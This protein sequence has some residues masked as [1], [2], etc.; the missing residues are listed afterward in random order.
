MHCENL[1]YIASNG[2]FFQR[3]ARYADDT[4]RIEGDQRHRLSGSVQGESRININEFLR[5]ASFL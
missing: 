2:I 1:R 3:R 4:I 5:S